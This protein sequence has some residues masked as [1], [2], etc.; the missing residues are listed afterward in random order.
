MKIKLLG[1]RSSVP[2]SPDSGQMYGINT[3]SILVELDDSTS[4]VFDAGTGIRHYK[5][6]DQEN[7]FLLLSH[8][9]W[10]HIQGFPFWKPIYTEGQKINIYSSG[11]QNQ[12]PIL[13]QLD[14]VSFPIHYSNLPSQ[15]QTKDLSE[16][17]SDFVAATG[18]DDFSIEFV[19]LHHP[20]G[21]YGCKFSHRGVKVA[22]LFDHEITSLD[23]GPKRQ[24]WLSLISDCSMV[25]HDLQ[26]TSGVDEQYRGWGHTFD[27]DLS[28]LLKGTSINNLLLF[29]HGPDDSDQFVDERVKSIQHDLGSGCLVSAAREKTEWYHTEGYWREG[30]CQL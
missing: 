14:N 18:I 17:S 20:G 19:L 22:F 5:P 12:W 16:F 30:L 25:V 3:P 9:H 29:G 11:Y 24:E 26:Y 7:I 15:I 27:K 28:N 6:D 10:D 8:Q 1:V 23:L 21:A 2:S 13:T 4:F